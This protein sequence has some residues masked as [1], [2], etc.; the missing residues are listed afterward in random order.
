M[1]ALPNALTN[2][3]HQRRPCGCD[4]CPRCP[5]V[6]SATDRPRPRRCIAVA[7]LVSQDERMSAGRS[8]TGEHAPHSTQRPG[9][10]QSGE[11]WD[12]QAT[13]TAVHGDVGPRRVRVRQSGNGPQKPKRPQARRGW[14]PTTRPM[15]VRKVGAVKQGRNTVR[16]SASEHGG[17][18]GKHR[19]ITLTRVVQTPSMLP[20][21]HFKI[22]N[23]TV[24]G[25]SPRP[26]D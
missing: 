16:R 1:S 26:A 21:S 6:I 17:G 4:G 25:V 2:A 11:Q 5:V 3:Q 12:R 24:T 10:P 7:G 20:S 18:A 8:A 23:Q 19:R 15:N 22:T 13:S 9:R 14:A